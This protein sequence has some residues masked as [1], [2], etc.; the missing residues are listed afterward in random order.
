MDDSLQGA[1]MVWRWPTLLASRK[2][3]EDQG[4]LR[5]S[6]T[7]AGRY[8][9][10]LPRGRLVGNRSG[11]LELLLSITHHAFSFVTHRRLVIWRQASPLMVAVARN[12]PAHLSCHWWQEGETWAGESEMSSRIRGRPRIVSIWMLGSDST[13]YGLLSTKNHGQHNSLFHVKVS[14]TVDEID[15]QRLWSLFTADDLGPL[16]RLSEK[17]RR[18][19]ALVYPARGKGCEAK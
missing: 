15:G 10:W 9:G 14:R 6:G 1:V 5:E 12:W 17:E 7:I 3:E 19:V 4:P 11:W 8:E 18:S 2:L 16:H 13:Q